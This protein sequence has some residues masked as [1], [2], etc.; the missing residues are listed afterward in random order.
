MAIRPGTNWTVDD[1]DYIGRP[2]E[3]RYDCWGTAEVLTEY[4]EGIAVGQSMEGISDLGHLHR[5]LLQE[6][7]YHANGRTLLKKL[8]LEEENERF[9][10][11]GSKLPEELKAILLALDEAGIGSSN[12]KR[13]IQLA[14]ED[15]TTL[16]WIT[17]NWETFMEVSQQD[18]LSQAEGEL[19]DCEDTGDCTEVVASI[20]QS[21]SAGRDSYRVVEVFKKSFFKEAAERRLVHLKE[22]LRSIQVCTFPQEVE[23]LLWTIRQDYE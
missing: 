9:G 10:F 18:A 21:G 20:N 11:D 14:E 15:E 1:L 13:T 7:D 19:N 8:S 16:Q 12:L 23:Q 5:Q 22:R 6:S 2:R 4:K 3:D 17:E